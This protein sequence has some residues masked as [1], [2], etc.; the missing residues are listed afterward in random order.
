VGVLVPSCGEVGILTGAHCVRKNGKN[1]SS[2]VG[3]TS[4]YKEPATP[5]DTETGRQA[6]WHSGYWQQI[7]KQYYFPAEA[8]Q[9]DLEFD[10]AYVGGLTLSQLGPDR[11]PLQLAE[12]SPPRGHPVMTLRWNWKSEALQSNFGFSLGV[13]DEGGFDQYAL[14][15]N[16]GDSGS[17]VVDVSG[18]LAGIV[19]NT[20]RDKSQDISSGGVPPKIIRKLLQAACQAKQ[21]PKGK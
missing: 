13:A 15:A 8:V 12:R 20:S 14:E 6:A 21:K 4:F 3:L 9:L 7:E 19:I 18:Q 11:Q 1:F 10:L 5:K 16:P 2:I 17:M